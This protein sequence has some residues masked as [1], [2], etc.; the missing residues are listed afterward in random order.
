MMHALLALVLFNLRVE[1][2]YAPKGIDVVQPRLSWG[3]L[4]Q[5]KNVMQTAYQVLVAS[6]PEKLAADNGDLWNSGKVTS[7]QSTQV[8]YKGKPLISRQSCYWKVRIWTD[9]G[10]SEWSLP[11]QWSMG[12][13]QPKDWK[14]KWIGSDTAYA[15]DSAHTQFSRLSARYY[16]KEFKTTDTV[17]KATLY[18]AGPG[19]YEGFINGARV[20][21][22]VLAQSPT[23]FRK[24]VKYNTYDVTALLKKGINNINVTLG[25]GRYFTMR[26]HYKPKKITTF[27]YPRLLLQLEL[28][29]AS[30]KKQLVV[31][32]QSWQ[33]TADGPILT[34]NEYDG[35]EYDARKEPTN[36]S[37]ATIVPAPGGR[38]EAQLNEPQRVTAQLRPVSV[39]KVKDHWIV[40]MG[41][42]MAGW[43]KIKVQGQR[44]Q[45]V[46][47]RFAE[48]LNKDSTLFTA[49]LRDAKVTDIYTLK[50]GAP[51][52][53][54]PSFVYHGFRYVEISGVLPHEIEGQVIHDDLTFTGKFHTSDPTLNQIYQ[55]AC[56]GIRSNYKGMPVDCPQRNER[57]PWLGDRNTSAWGESFIFGN[58]NLY[59]KWLDDIEDAQ[60]PNGAIPD[61]APAYWKYYSDNMTWPAAYP[62][63]AGYL[64]KQYGDVRPIEK[65]YASMKRW[66]AYMQEHYLADGIMTK[67]K[68][69]DWCVPPETK[70]QIHARDSNRITDNKLI[71]TATY[72]QMLQLMDTFAGILHL[73]ADQ[74]AYA[75]QIKNAFN[76][77]FFINQRYSNNTVTANLLPLY[78]NMV[79]A[80]NRQQVFENVV[81]KIHE[82]G[83]HISTG[84]VGTQY[85]MRGLTAN[86]R[87]DLAYQIAADRDYPG[88]GYMAANGAT[89]IWELWNGNTAAPN[90]NSQNHV[91]LLGDLVLWFYQDLAGIKSY[92]GFKHIIMK[93]QP[94]PG[95]EEVAAS[96]ESIH[97]KIVSHWKKTANAFH[98]DISIPPN[99]TATVYLPDS[100]LQQL[101]SGDYTFN[102]QQPNRWK[103]GIMTDED[104]C[105]N[106]P[107][108]ESH[109]S[110]IAETD[111]GL[112]TAWFGG[113]KER[114]PDVGIWVSRQV[115]GRWTAPV[116]VANGIQSD[117]LRYACWNPVLFQMPKG[118][119]LLFYKVGPNVGGW[120]G[121]MK[122]SKDGGITWSAARP[123]PDGFLGPVKNKPILLSNGTLLCP[124]STEGHGWNIHFEL[125]ADT[126]RTWT[127][128]GPL[129]KDSTINAI[130]PSIL[131]Y[132]NGKLQ[133]LCR[134]KGG[135]VVQA[136]SQD[137]GKTWSPLSLTNLPNNNS[138]TD[139]VTLQDGRQLIVYNHIAT[140]KGKSKG[141]RTPLNVSLSQDGVN[142]SAAL[143][144]EDSPVSQYSYPSVIQ[145]KDGYIHIV[146]TW[147]R[148][149]IRYVK[150]DPRQLELTP[151]KNGPWKTA[152]ADL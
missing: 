60:L 29:Y 104:I 20:G 1:M 37:R 16:K 25:N 68:Y 47:M 130:Q 22:Q 53:W 54:H 70:T 126:G 81:Q 78:F 91:M 19:L 42:N 77:K 102:I 92:D 12:L 46:I 44:G 144:L 21:T 28:E 124:S 63:I 32:D 62:L 120:K 17:K 49:N 55:N 99:T 38:L 93:P 3:M 40:D 131:Q 121:Y 106:P 27:G 147:R 51:E 26:Q 73:P 125:T 4:S 65:H 36:W 87:P 80:E 111:S 66:L 123:L 48:S 10:Q 57:M 98:W 39:K 69:G 74:A 145:S 135:N 59:A 143:V 146:Y 150:I 132:A 152:D 33:Q 43:V 107:F 75:E 128:V 31:S 115:G 2:L 35:E 119:L 95:L 64:Y 114:N 18:I 13:L 137:G 112:V 118:D 89:T 134:N 90:M 109:A 96:Y 108:P 56:W 23:D 30:G 136:W 97:G 103:K 151:L 101:G 133:I 58:N 141:P 52:T 116:E 79:P 149:R 122:T 24:R 67:D 71:A 117:T 76:K 139:A 113:T 8:V 72:Y 138:G 85:L 110:T 86:G 140:P 129:S 11:G 94:V 142:W 5:E 7:D 45:Q 148:Q 88:W 9:K 61:V 105:T 127:K 6:T 100:S 15:W 41:Q 82:N 84:V 14:A 34:N 50:G 83:N